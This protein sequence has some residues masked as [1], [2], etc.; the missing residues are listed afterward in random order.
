[1]DVE[2]TECGRVL[3]LNESGVIKK[4]DHVYVETYDHKISELKSETDADRKLIE[5]EELRKLI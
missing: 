3:K 1:M 5:K 4:T 2:G